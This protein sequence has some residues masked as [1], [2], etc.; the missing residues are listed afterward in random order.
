MPRLTL[1]ETPTPEQA[2]VIAEVVAGKRGRVPGPMI[3]WLPNPELARRAQHLGA[4]LRYD[5][6]LEPV[7]SELAILI[8]GRHWT[9]HYEWT[10]HKRIA[11]EVG[12]DPRTIADIA[13]RNP[14]PFL[15]N[16]RE[17]A[18]FAVASTLMANSR[19]DDATYAR[20]IG[21]L[22]ER[23]MV[24]LVGILGYYSMVALTLN[25]FELGLP[26]SYAPELETPVAGATP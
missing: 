17:T 13:A 22:G 16:E 18:V 9:S 8:C 10:A 7:L 19:I 26:D 2:E 5:T 25:A 23:G 24:D 20:G 3:G 12:L 1:P 4:L 15:R 11:L 6:S 14:A 21:A